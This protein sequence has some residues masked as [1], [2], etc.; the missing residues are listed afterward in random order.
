[1]GD[2]TRTKAALDAENAFLRQQLV[3]LGRQLKRPVLFPPSGGSAGLA[4]RPSAAIGRSLI[5]PPL[6]R[7]YPSIR[8]IDR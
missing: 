1:V 8:S 5:D 6:S 4:A 7:L 3:V 2:L